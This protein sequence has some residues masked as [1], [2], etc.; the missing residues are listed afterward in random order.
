MFFFLGWRLP[1]LLIFW[2]GSVEPIS[3]NSATNGSVR[4]VCSLREFTGGPERFWISRRHRRRDARSERGGVQV[5]ALQSRRKDLHPTPELHRELKR[6]QRGKCHHV[7]N[8]KENVVSEKFDCGIKVIW[9][10]SCYFSMRY[11]FDRPLCVVDT[12]YNMYCLLSLENGK[13]VSYGT[14]LAQTFSAVFYYVIWFC[15]RPGVAR[16]FCSRDI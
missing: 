6:R 15:S 8:S 3:R 12:M 9:S 10:H 16:L 1:W 14:K 7:W 4:Q 2:K 13:R 5:C 11:P